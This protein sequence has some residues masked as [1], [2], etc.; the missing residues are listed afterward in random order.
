MISVEEALGHVHRCARPLPQKRLPLGDTLGRRLAEAIVSEVD[1]PPFDKA[2]LDGYAFSVHDSSSTLSVTEQVLA[3]GVPHHAVEPGT[4]ILVMTGAPV[5]DGADVVIKHEDVEHLEESI[6]QFPE[7]GVVEGGGI[8]SRGTAF[9]RGQEVLSAGKLITP[10]DLAL[11][12]ELGRAKVSVT[13]RP[14]VAV[15]ATGNELVEVGRPLGPARICNSNGPMLLALLETMRVGATDLGIGRDNPDVLRR[16]IT[17]GISADVLLVTG[18]VSAGVMDLV[19]DVLEQLGVEKV[20]HKVRIKPG[21]P[22]WF[23]KREHEGKST[24]VFG[25]PGNPVSTLV[26]FELFVKPALLALGGE[27]LAAATPLCGILTDS[28]AHRGKRTT[29]NPCRIN[30]GDCEE[31]K[32]RVELLPWRGSA[33]LAAMTHANALAVLPA[34][35]YELAAGAEVELLRLSSHYL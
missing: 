16:L 19:P 26:A 15:L 17:E 25:L 24:L 23:G 6:I 30:F 11:L 32:P 20:F 7:T 8:M 9:H 14:E 13:P 22:L 21:K 18:G 33:D 2:M 27:D 4:T 12:A 34:G 1:S 10:I 35:D 5:P 29:Y 31:G 3:G 28:I